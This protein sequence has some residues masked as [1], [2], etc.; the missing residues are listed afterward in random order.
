MILQIVWLKIQ[1]V[2]FTQEVYKLSAP[3][4]ITYNDAVKIAG[5][6]A[7][8]SWQRKWN[9]DVSD[10]YT[11]SLIP[12]VRVKVSFLRFGILKYHTVVQYF[13]ILCYVQC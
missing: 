6:T 12:V 4:F 11:R 8:K 1:H 3:S 10:F 7:I 2:I 13:V 9:Q 5:D